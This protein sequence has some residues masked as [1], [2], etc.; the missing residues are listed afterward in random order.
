[1]LDT[2]PK[3]V[4]KVF[5]TSNFHTIIKRAGDVVSESDTEQWLNSDDGDPGYQVLSQE[6]IAQNL[7]QG[8]ED[9]DDADEEETMLKKNWL[10]FV[11]N[12]Q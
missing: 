3:N 4:F 2:E 6:E 8:K 5:E 12:Y 11:I 9:D 10:H 1:L 7:M